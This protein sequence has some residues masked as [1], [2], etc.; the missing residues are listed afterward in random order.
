MCISSIK[1][2]IKDGRLYKHCCDIYGYG[3]FIVRN[4]KNCENLV[5]GEMCKNVS[6]PKKTKKI[7]GIRYYLCDGCSNILIKKCKCGF[8]ANWSNINNDE[9]NYC[10][11]CAENEFGICNIKHINSKK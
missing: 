10:F 11:D 2:Y 5:N 1:E 4:H 8:I 3:N 9:Y 7:N 6:D